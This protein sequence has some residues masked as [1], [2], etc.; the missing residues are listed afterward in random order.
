[1]W[2][3]TQP[4]PPLSAT[5]PA[6]A[7]NI[8]ARDAANF[9]P[10]TLNSTLLIRLTLPFLSRWW[11]ERLHETLRAWTNIMRMNMLISVGV[12]FSPASSTIAIKRELSPSVP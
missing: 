12:E 1:M 6:R 2:C 10:L 5:D 3:W 11:I 4:D 8:A 9:R 7:E